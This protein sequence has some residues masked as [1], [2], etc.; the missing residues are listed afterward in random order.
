MNTPLSIRLQNLTAKAGTFTHIIGRE[1]ELKRL[2]QI[3]MMPTHHHAVIYGE[4]GIGKSSLVEMLAL[5][6]A[7][8][9]LPQ[10]PPKVYTLDTAPILSLFVGGNSLSSCFEALRSNMARLGQAIVV[11]EDIQLLASDEPGRLELTMELLEAITSQ[12]DIRLV[13]TTTETAFRQT[14]RP[15]YIFNRTF[16]P[17]ELTTLNTDV[18]A[19]I[20]ENAAARM[21]TTAGDTIEQIIHLSERYG[22]GRAIPDAALRLLEEVIVKTA[23]DG[24]RTITVNDVRATISERER[25]PLASLDSHNHSRLAGLENYLNQAVVGQPTAIKTITRIITN[26]QLGISDE[27]RPRGSF[28]ILGPSGV[29]KTETAKALTQVVYANPKSLIRLDMSEYSEPHTALRLT[30][31]PPGYVGYEEGGQLTSAVM[32]QPYSLVLLDEIEKAHTKLFDVFLQLLDDGRLTDS[33]G[34]TV[35][36]TQTTLIATSNIGSRQIAEAF[37]QGTKVD[38]PEFLRQTLLP[39]LMEHFRPEFLNRF[40]AILVYQPLDIPQ[41]VAVAQRELAKL[42]NRLAR[43]GVTFSVPNKT[44]AGLIQTQYDP[45]FGARPVKRLV[46]TYFETPIAEQIVSGQ[47]HSPI[48]ITGDESWLNLNTSQEVTC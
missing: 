39:L 43:L 44:L 28:L 20:L 27:S 21:G 1:N 33:S 31:S 11:V 8:G 18:I 36:F 2:A 3:L 40:D 16:V 25:V 26:A 38:S 48:T 6:I 24:R 17:C 47:L 22:H 23:F 42:Q 45:L 30:G 46:T 12:P 41:L 34:K 5:G 4:P 13:V 10:L 15:N 7:E 9:A 37:T 35:D 29:G 19:A 32:R 14:F